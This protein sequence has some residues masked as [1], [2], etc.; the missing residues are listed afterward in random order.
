[1][2]EWV[3]LSRLMH[4]RRSPV[5]CLSIIRDTY[6]REPHWNA[7]WATAPSWQTAVKRLAADDA[8]GAREEAGAWAAK[9][10]GAPDGR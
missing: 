3:R 6:S 1:M 8:D 4:V 7:Y 9:L 10:E 5:A 2:P